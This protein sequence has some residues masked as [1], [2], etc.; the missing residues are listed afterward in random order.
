MRRV[1]RS[2][3]PA[4]YAGINALDL[5]PSEPMKPETFASAIA[6]LQANFGM[7]Y[8]PEKTA[9]LFDMIRDEMWSEE[10]FNRT[11]KWFL[12]NKRYAAWTI[13]DWFDYGVKVYPYSWM[14]KQAFDGVDSAKSLECYELPDGQFVW[15]MRDGETLPFKLRED[16]VGR[17][18]HPRGESVESSARLEQAYKE[19]GI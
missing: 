1:S 9:I 10:R 16:L 5:I 17:S 14:L 4:A 11:F 13:A 15:K 2:E 8:S 12:K 3:T 18:N 19:L 7:E 6:I